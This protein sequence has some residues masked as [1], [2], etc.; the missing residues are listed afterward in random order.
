M[1]TSCSMWQGPGWPLPAEFLG[2]TV[3]LEKGWDSQK[4]LPVPQAQVSSPPGTGGCPRKH[5]YKRTVAALPC[6]ARGCAPLRAGSH[7]LSPA[8]S[9]RPCTGLCG[10][11]PMDHPPQLP[12]DASSLF[13][14]SLHSSTLPNMRSWLFPPPSSINSPNPAVLPAIPVCQSA[15]SHRLSPPPPHPSSLCFPSLSVFPSLECC[16]TN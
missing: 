3:K 4:T 12:P 7:L 6:P 11:S 16:E 13:P 5:L 1:G 15:M 9:T 8:V 10:C 14:V 2:V